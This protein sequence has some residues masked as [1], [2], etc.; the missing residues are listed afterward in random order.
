MSTIEQRT[1]ERLPLE[2][3]ILPF[4]GSREEDYQP[5]QY[6]IQDFSQNGVRIA[7]PSWLQSREKLY[8]G[9]RVNLHLPYKFQGQSRNQ[10]SVA[11]ETWEDQAA[12]QVCGVALDKS[13][14]ETYPV[15]IS[16][17]TRELVIGLENF[18]DEA[19]LLLLVL[20]D[21]AMLKRG[22]LI[23][24]EH[25]ATY[26]TRVSEFS[27]EEYALFRRMI[28]NDIKTGMQKNHDYL[29]SLYSKALS[30]HS[31]N[32]DIMEILD[33]DELRQ[34]V[35]SEIYVDLFSSVLSIET[36]NMYLMALKTLEKKSYNNYNTLVM[37]YLNSL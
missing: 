32:Q 7:I 17:E 8:R 30:L 2:M 13:F 3:A 11:W 16:L 21:I 25:L 5:F 15:F 20:K 12:A 26:F 35:Q 19:S 34:S 18:E 27:R 24:L 10:G 23:Y 9:D 36:I 4:L 6:I 29:S 14:P 1:E 28:I 31:R 22:M 33:I 37:L